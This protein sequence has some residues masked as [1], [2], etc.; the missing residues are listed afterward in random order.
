[1]SANH[2]PPNLVPIEIG[3]GPRAGHGFGL[4]VS[5]LVDPPCLQYAWQCRHLRMGRL[6]HDS[7]LDR[8]RGKPDRPCL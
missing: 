6:G 7:I 5:A 3:D 2:L 8:P 1:M 4:G